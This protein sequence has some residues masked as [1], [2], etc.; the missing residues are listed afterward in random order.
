MTKKV[1]TQ[2]ADKIVGKQLDYKTNGDGIVGQ[3]L[4]L[5]HDPRFSSVLGTGI[6]RRNFLQAGAAMDQ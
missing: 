6:S 1:T 5:D 3:D 4:L 2:H